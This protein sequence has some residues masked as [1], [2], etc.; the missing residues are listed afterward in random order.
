[1]NQGF[2]RDRAREAMGA[3]CRYMLA[4]LK[5]TAAAC[6]LGGICGLLGAGF[7]EAIDLATNFRMNHGFIIW[8][9]PAAGLIT[10]LL[11]QLCRVSFGAGTNLIIQSVTTNEHI[12]AFL[13]P[14]I[15][16]GTLLS[17]L[18]GAS[19]GREGAA[20]QLGGSIGH[21]LAELLRFDEDDV[22]TVSM[23][24]MAACFSAMFG[25]P[26]TAAIFVLEV[27]TVGSLHYGAF[28]PCVLA[29]YTAAAVS[30]AL[31]IQPMSYALTGHPGHQPEMVGRVILLAALC[32]LVAILLCFT[33]HQAS[34][35]AEKLVKNAYLRIAA[36]GLAMAVLVSS[37]GLTDFAGAGGHMIQRAVD[38]TAEP[39][40]FL[41][42]L[43][44]T[45]LCVGSGF[46]GGEIV[47]T[48]FIGAAFGCAVGPLLGL[49]ASFAAAI[50]MVCVFCGVVN[51]PIATVFL[52][53]EMFSTVDIGLFAIAIA[54]AFVLSGYTGLYSSQVI[55]FSKVKRQARHPEKPQ[56]KREP[57]L[58]K[59]I[60]K[61]T[62]LSL[63]DQVDYQPGQVVSKTLVQSEAMSMTLFSFDKGVEISACKADGEAM[64]T[65]LEGTGRFTVGGQVF[66]LGPGET[67]VM[68]KGI[69]HA[70]FGEERF[71]MQLVVSF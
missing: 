70:V 47:P 56:E 15:V 2:Y 61:Q 67:L 60:E 7:H 19:V 49:D 42:K 8:F 57:S 66:L 53:V 45:A 41:V 18:F 27:I 5:W 28:L 11:Y 52:A 64:A 43:L 21:N 12:P 4:A 69:P 38:G 1:M 63:K 51:C 10:L 54:V 17:H 46:R 14:L 32:A 22:R 62:V 36:G 13:A 31:G 9:L 25:T 40:A 71:K 34:R 20:L 3:F 39:W 33:L 59:N 65:V 26:L 50:G 68:P 55:L 48:L 23:C 6:G 29:S 16:A 37:L 58:Y 24:G 30:R 44:L 35:L